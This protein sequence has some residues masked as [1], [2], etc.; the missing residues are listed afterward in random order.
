MSQV[1]RRDAVKMVAGMGIVATGVGVIANR[2][3][4]S[5]A[6]TKQKETTGKPKPV[7]QVVEKQDKHSKQIDKTLESALRNPSGFM[8]L[9]QV[10]FKKPHPKGNLF[11]TSA[12]GKPE[13]DSTEVE[14]RPGTMRIFRAIADQDAF[15]RQGGVYWKN[16]NTTGKIQ[17][18]HPGALILAVCEMDGTVNCYSM[19]NDLRC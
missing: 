2:D 1:S 13:R 19:M 5:E 7:Q 17:F 10:A 4:D 15:T 12:Y 6:A 18:K 16:R 8:F 9:E 14:L 11:F 3:S